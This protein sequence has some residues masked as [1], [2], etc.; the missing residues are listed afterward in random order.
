MEI[1]CAGFP[2]TGTKSCT[3]ALRELGY[4]VADLRETF[5][6]LMPTWKNYFEGAIEIEHVVRK[7]NELGYTVSQDWPSN[8]LWEELFHASPKSKVILTVRDS[9]EV[10]WN[11]LIRFLRAERSAAGNPGYWILLKCLDF[12]MM[13]PTLAASDWIAREYMDKYLPNVFYWKRSTSWEES[14]SSLERC[15]DI[16]K[17]LYRKHIEYVKSVVPADRLLIWNLNDGWAPIYDF[18]NLKTQ[19]SFE[20]MNESFP[21]VN[22]T[23]DTFLAEQLGHIFAD[24]QEHLKKNLR[25]LLLALFLLVI[26][27]IC[28]LYGLL[29]LVNALVRIPWE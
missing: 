5:D 8:M 13:G 4:D 29:V 21:R 9:D 10:W 6:D 3:Q 28:M 23:G 27:L 20:I 1:I 12:Q 26:V 16:H 11:S 24:G 2:K 25:K 15:Q 14:V 7:Y 22:K 17:Q 18:L 19:S